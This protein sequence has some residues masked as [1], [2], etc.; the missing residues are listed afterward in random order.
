[1]TTQDIV[2]IL[3][4]F[5]KNYELLEKIVHMLLKFDEPSPWMSFIHR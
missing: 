4:R 5:D 1:L 2:Y 3:L